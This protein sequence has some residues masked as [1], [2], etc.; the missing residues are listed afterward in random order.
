M[1]LSAIRKSI[2][3]AVATGILLT[4]SLMLTGNHANA[5][6]GG[7]GCN[8]SN[9]R[10][11]SV[12]ACTNFSWP[13]LNGDM[14]ITLSTSSDVRI[15]TCNGHIALHDDTTRTDV[16]GANFNCLNTKYADA[17]QDF[18]APGGY[19]TVV[20]INVTYTISGTTYSGT[21]NLNSP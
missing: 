20:H 13:T 15:L 1:H 4:G 19:V 12:G 11:L 7:G 9:G 10:V 2:R 8:Q 17:Y 3:A 18:P 16:A 14:Y 21:I 6:V 5:S